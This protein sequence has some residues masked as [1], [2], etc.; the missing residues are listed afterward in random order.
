[1]NRETKAMFSVAGWT[2]T[3]CVSKTEHQSTLSNLRSWMKRSS[4]P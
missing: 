3:E 1:M 2:A 4:I